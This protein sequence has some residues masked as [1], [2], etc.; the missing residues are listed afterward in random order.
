M[1]SLPPGSPKPPMCHDLCP[2]HR[3]P[4]RWPIARHIPPLPPPTLPHPNPACTFGISRTSTHPSHQSN[5]TYLSAVKRHLP[6]PSPRGKNIQ[7]MST[8]QPTLKRKTGPSL[9]DSTTRHRP[10]PN[11]PARTSPG[12]DHLGHNPIPKPA[13]YHPSRTPQP[14]ILRPHVP[15]RDCLRK[16]LPATTR[17]SHDKQGRDLNISEEDLAKILDVSLASRKAGTRESYGSGLLSYHLF[18]DTHNIPEDQRVPAD[19]KL[20]ASFMASIGGL[21]AGRTIENYLSSV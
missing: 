4:S 2:Q 3:Q 6:Y 11:H 9:S 16:W 14:S 1:H 13:S 15:C 8:L 18:C 19:S 21:Y 20:V 10:L 7:K 5:N 12:T 17:D